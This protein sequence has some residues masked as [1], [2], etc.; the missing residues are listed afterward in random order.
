MSGMTRHSYYEQRDKTNY[1]KTKAKTQGKHL[2]GN[3]M[4]RD[5]ISGNFR[6]DGETEVAFSATF[7]PGV[8]C[9]CG[10]VG[11]DIPREWFSALVRHRPQGLP[12]VGLLG[13]PPW[14]RNQRGSLLSRAVPSPFARPCRSRPVRPRPLSL[15]Q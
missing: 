4:K 11:L 3:R 6:G 12:F 10:G 7:S 15:A 13:L 9:A 2:I 5:R 14:R 8:W 1:P